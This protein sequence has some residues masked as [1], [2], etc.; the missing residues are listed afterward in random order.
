LDV[1][2]ERGVTRRF[3]WIIIYA[4][5]AIGPNNI[6]DVVCCYCDWYRS[7][8]NSLKLIVAHE[9]GVCRHLL[10]LRL[11]TSVS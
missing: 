6:Y 5:D 11:H 8:E 9:F 3:G 10:Q 2:Y 4:C 1:I 7:G